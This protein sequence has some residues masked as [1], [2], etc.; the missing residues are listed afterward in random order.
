MTCQIHE[1]LIFAHVF[2]VHICIYI[3]LIVDY[4]VRN[5]IQTNILF[6]HRRDMTTNGICRLP[7][8]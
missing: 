7:E 5:I 2:F 6:L 1:I 4:T 3:L 8:L